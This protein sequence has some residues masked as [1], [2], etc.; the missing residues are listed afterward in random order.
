MLGGGIKDTLLCKMTSSACNCEVKAGPTE[1]TVMGNIGVVYYALGE[2]KDFCDLRKVISAS[3]D[4]KKYS[5]EDA[6]TWETA[7]KTYLKVIGK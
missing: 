1:A 4:I 3:T 2:I 6:S 5:P 7:Y